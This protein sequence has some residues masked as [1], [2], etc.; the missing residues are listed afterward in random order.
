MKVKALNQSGLTIV[1]LMISVAIATV[2]AGVLLTVSVGF[3]GD[4]IR[5]QA[6]AQMAVESHFMLRSVIE[7]MRLA[8]RVNTENSLTDINEPATEWITGDTDNILVLSKPATDVS[9]QIIYNSET[10]NPHNN[11]L[12]YFISDRTLYKRI[13]ANPN[14]TGNNVTTTCPAAAASATCP[15]D[16]QY[17]KDVDDLTLTFYD[18]SNN[19]VT[20]LSTARSVRVGLLTSRRIFGKNVSFNNSILAKLR[21]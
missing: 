8:D 5:S 14:A 15:P 4:T 18:A 21:N 9:N 10:G 11:E 7:D 3:F 6:T 1:E 19:E 20:D 16:R 17:S 13:L 12:I 2:L